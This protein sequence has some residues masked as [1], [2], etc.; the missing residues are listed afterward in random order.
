MSKTVVGVIGVLAWASMAM[1]G[2][3]ANAQSVITAQEQTSPTQPKAKKREQR[4]RRPPATSAP[5]S[6]SAAKNTG[7][8]VKKFWKEQDDE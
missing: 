2:E 7:W 5:A 6:S 8:D 4:V 3:L 1:I